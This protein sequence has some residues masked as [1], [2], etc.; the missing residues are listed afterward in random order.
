M[1]G[2]DALRRIEIFDRAVVVPVLALLA[3]TVH[4]ALDSRSARELLLATA[5]AES[6]LTDGVQLGGGPA[7]SR[8]QVEDRTLA[9]IGGWLLDRDDAEGWLDAIEEVLPGWIAPLPRPGEADWHT[10]PGSLAGLHDHLAHNDFLGAVMARALYWSI[11][12]PL[13]ASGNWLGHAA[14]WKSYYNSPFGAGTPAK[15][16][17]RT[18]EVRRHFDP[19]EPP[20]E[21]S[22]TTASGDD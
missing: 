4:P 20:G 19:A 18:A 7:R 22:P 11:P 15:F 3:H 1:S 5:V 9:L 17:A 6:D 21:T 13:P 2:S 8:F 10:L 16:L 12:H 14:Y